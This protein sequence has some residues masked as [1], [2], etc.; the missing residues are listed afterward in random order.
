MLTQFSKILIPRREKK[1]V[2]HYPYGLTYSFI[3]RMQKYPSVGLNPLKTM[4]SVA[5]CWSGD[6]TW[7]TS[8]HK[9]RGRGGS[10]RSGPRDL[11]YAIIFLVKSRNS[12]GRHFWWLSPMKLRHFWK[13]RERIQTSVCYVG[14]LRTRS[15]N[16]SHDDFSHVRRWSLAARQNIS[17]DYGTKFMRLKWAKTSVQVSNWRSSCSDN[18]NIW[19][20]ASRTG[21]HCEMRTKIAAWER[22]WSFTCPCTWLVIQSWE[23][24]CFDILVGSSFLQWTR[25]MASQVDHVSSIVGIQIFRFPFH[26][27]LFLATG[28]LF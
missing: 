4:I 13:S 14:L 9:G 17:N 21:R 16:L 7:A 27:T 3:Y 23:F 1:F 15:A 18:Y 5:K 28:L 12:E 2:Y 22:G 8:L 24:H 6:G 11:V 19:I 20:I 25:N 26:L 10:K